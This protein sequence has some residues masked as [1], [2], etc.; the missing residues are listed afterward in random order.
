MMDVQYLDRVWRNAIEHFVGIANERYHADA[1]H[2]LN[3]PKE[4]IVNSE[5]LGA[6]WRIQDQ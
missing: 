4:S 6:A 3:R 2:S 5:F 1:R